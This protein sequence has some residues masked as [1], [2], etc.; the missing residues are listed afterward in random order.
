MAHA[1]HIY[2]SVFL[3]SKMEL[4]RLDFSASHFFFSPHH[5][6]LPPLKNPLKEARVHL[7]EEAIGY[8]L[9][10]RESGRAMAAWLPNMNLIA[11]HL[12]GFL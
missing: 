12:G 1:K 3:S 8:C 7:G 5:L 9:T 6:C 2:F 11:G 10:F 4:D